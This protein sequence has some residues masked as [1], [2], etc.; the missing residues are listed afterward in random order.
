MFG[1]FNLMSKKNLRKLD[2]E[3]SKVKYDDL[4]AALNQLSH[5]IIDERP[6][7]KNIE[8]LRVIYAITQCCLEL[9]KIYE[10]DK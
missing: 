10:E 9:Q 3:L 7:D 2:A 6:A 1:I 5:D 8:E 4:I